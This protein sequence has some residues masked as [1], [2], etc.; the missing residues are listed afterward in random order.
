MKSA[1][2]AAAVRYRPLK[3]AAAL[4]RH[5]TFLCLIFLLAGP[6][7][8]ATFNVD[9]GSTDGHDSHPGDGVC[10]DGTGHCSLR[11]AIEEGNALA[12]THI[13]NLMPS[14][15]P[16]KIINGSMAQLRAQYVLN[17]NHVTIDGNGRGCL[18]LTDS[19]TAALGHATGAAN[20]MVTNVVIGNCNGAGISANGHGYVFTGNF[21]GVDVTG[22]MAVPN[23][24]SGITL[25]ASAYYPDNTTLQNI[26]NALPTLPVDFSTINQFNIGLTN[27]L[28]AVAAPVT[29]S[30]NVISGNMQY[31]VEIHGTNMAAVF[32]SGNHIGTDLLGVTSIPNQLSGVRI[33]ATSYGNMIGPGNVISGNGQHGILVDSGEVLLP[34]FIMG[35]RIGLGDVSSAH[36]G[37]SSSGI[38]VDTKPAGA[39]PGPPNPSGTSLMIGPANLIS[40]NKGTNN[41]GF[42]DDVSAESNAGVVITGS[43]SS[44]KVVG[45]TI[46]MAEFPTG[47][48]LASTAYGNA[49]DGILI[50]SSGNTI[51]GS[52]A[53]SANIIAGNA[54]HGIVIKGSSTVGNTILGNYIGKHSGFASRMDLGNGVDGI[55][56]D[57]AST[58]VIGGSGANDGNIIA[59]NGRNGIALRNGGS[60]NGWSNL[61]QRNQIYGNAKQGSGIGIDLEHT[62]N[63]ADDPAHGEFPS[64]YANGDQVQPVI[65]S[66]PADSGACSG[67]A[68]PAYAGGNT[69]L[70]W[71][72]STHGPANFRAEFFAINAASGNAATS[73]SFLGEQTVATTL[74]GGLSGSGCSATRCTVQLPADTRGAG[75]V[76][77]IT[78]ITPLTDQPGGGSDWKSNLKCFVGNLGIILPS[79]NVNNSSEFSNVA[80]IALPSSIPPVMANVPAQSATVGTAFSLNLSSYVTPTDGDPITGYMLAAGALPGG[81][82]LNTSSGLVSGTPTVAGSF[83][84]TINALD[85]DGASSAPAIQFTVAKAVQT[86]T[87]GTAPT[88]V[89]GGAPGTLT[90]TASSGLAV[91]FSSTTPDICTVNGT[92]VTP[93]AAGICTIAANQ[94]G[95]AS[96]AAAAQVTYIINVAKAKQSITFGAPPVMT[97]GGAA[98]TV[99]A[100]ASSGLAVVFSSNTPAVCSISGAT[101][102]ALSGGNCSIAADQA[103]NANYAAAAQTTQSF[104][105]A[106]PSQFRNALFVN[107]STSGNKTTVLRLIN[108][109]SQAGT[110]TATAYNEAGSVVGTPNVTLSSIAAQQMLTYTS[111]QLEAAIGYV[112]SSPTAKYRILFNANL[113]SFEI[114]NFIKDNATGNLTL[115][116]AQ[117][118]NRVVSAASSATRNAFF[119]NPST[120]ANKTSVVRV[121][122]VNGQSGS[123]T[124]TAYNEAG[125]VV[126]VS[127]SDLGAI[128]AQQMRTFTSA[129]LEAA[130][131]YVPSSPTAKYR[132][133]FTANLPNFEVVNFIKDNATGNLTLGQEQI[134]NRAASAAVS[135]TRN[136]WF[137][138]PST[139]LN[140][141]SVV[142]LINPNGQSGSVTA[143]A[144]NEAGNVV[145]T[146]NA[147][148]GTIAAQQ[149]LSF[150]SAQLETA[151]GY[152]PS[153]STA[154]YRIAF[155]ANLSNFEVIN[156]IKDTA[157][158]NLTLGQAQVDNRA[159]SAAMSSVR[160][161]L[162][163]NASSSANKTSVLRVINP[164][165]QSGTL[166]ATAYN[167][168]GAV[169]G[170]A[171]AN[172][173]TIGAQ[174]MLSYTSSQIETA[175]GYV[176]ASNTAKYRVVFSAN[177]PNFEVINFIKD[178]ATGNLTLGQD[179]I[180]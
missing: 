90:A 65:C 29:V 140:K 32:I 117:I 175:I 67:S 115:G 130:I 91:T 155:S 72:M 114:I 142:R 150:T 153:A 139:S 82:M 163:I 8:A 128:G 112:P 141:T 83:S 157:S 47:T 20:S 1:L 45:N 66:G 55:H 178:V 177:L 23:S 50:T 3:L 131:G 156:F 38:Y 14:A 30:G 53:G 180:D 101:V 129:Q 158:G 4:L 162:F 49:G 70:S 40:D 146:P 6:A 174:Q 42:P 170:T 149:M 167:E 119:V 71:T 88:L 9:I 161:A 169:V 86:I 51:G 39:T 137:V 24:G 176:P 120:S 37:N 95:N 160:N 17:G 77:R 35:N 165:N 87:F 92:L 41:N 171:A 84:A 122:N 132:V 36:V 107:A 13:I 148:L 135:S 68:A 12:G 109:G 125:G 124:A 126:G 78:D 31:G 99:S 10:N 54:R 18:D 19:G 100:T 98:G 133:V 134:D 168:A 138:N 74:G 61:I 85:K 64:N 5:L 103:G 89:Y 179:Q 104:T 56:I 93:V 173:G 48:A 96:Y 69:T 172:L 76:M 152:V 33:N 151:I 22:T 63:G 21:I 144:Y 106:G 60:A 73:M 97:Y 26:Y 62:M 127:N 11:A 105:I 108:L 57:A 7:A 102:T 2:P 27:A 52:S 94:A 79:C 143:T 16:I 15:S 25:T 59:A 164:N 123:L 118:D 159:S 46:G 136:A 44:V 147:S 75:I 121:I 43:S 111:A 116:Q 81:L 58:S 166:T 154:K 145:G 34:N 28:V 80:S 110:V 113:L